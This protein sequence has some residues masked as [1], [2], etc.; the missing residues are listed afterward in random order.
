MCSTAKMVEIV[1]TSVVTPSRDTPSDSIWLSNLDLLVARS[2]TPTVY[3]YRPT[4]DPAFFSVEPLKAALAETLVHFYPLA[5]RL[6]VDPTGQVEI[7]CTGEGVF[8]AVA[9]SEL[10]V[11]D[12]GDF[13]PSDEMRRMLVPAAESGDAPC[14]LVMFQVKWL[15]SFRAY[16][17]M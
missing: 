8:F 2:H 3:F 14:M 9:R 15:D 1:D 4:A 7:R 16:F 6:G 13:S 12:F 17:L 10:T 5:G 11:D